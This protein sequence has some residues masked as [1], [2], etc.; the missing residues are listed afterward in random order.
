MLHELMDQGKPVMYIDGVSCIHT[1]PPPV[2][3][4]SALKSKSKLEAFSSAQH[5]KDQ[6]LQLNLRA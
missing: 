5:L 1:N 4:T 2:K 6:I 3:G